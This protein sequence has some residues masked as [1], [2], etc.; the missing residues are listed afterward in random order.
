VPLPVVVL[1]SLALPL[2]LRASQWGAFLLALR[3]VPV[4]LAGNVIQLPGRSLFVT[5]ACSGL[6]SLTALIAL[7]L[8][9]GGI[10]LRSGWSR[11]ILVFVA[12]P[13]AM[14]LNAFRVFLT[15]FLVFYVDPRLAE[16]FMHYSEGWVIFVVAFAILGAGA[17]V[18]DL[19][20]RRLRSAPA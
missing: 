11:A 16:G 14:V 7:G 10:W 17:L 18:L 19:L 4:R 5:E 12:I 15:G 9:V 6:R 20:E 1:G 13:V 2:Q 8:L 3:H